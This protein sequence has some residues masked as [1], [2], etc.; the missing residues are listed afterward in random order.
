MANL[1]AKVSGSP[2]PPCDTE[3]ENKDQNA[4]RR[5]HGR[6]PEWYQQAKQRQTSEDGRR[7]Q[8]DGGRTLVVL[9]QVF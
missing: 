5:A 3:S 9:N 6:E 4:H 1:A 7:D 8:G 2:Q